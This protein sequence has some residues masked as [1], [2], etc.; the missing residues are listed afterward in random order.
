MKAAPAQS[1]Q[2]TLARSG[3]S[4]GRDPTE[5]RPSLA[6]GVLPM[7]GKTLALEHTREHATR[8][9]PVGTQLRAVGPP[10]LSRALRSGP[11]V[12]AQPRRRVGPGPGYPR[13]RPPPLRAISPGHQRARVALHDHV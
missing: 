10:P 9:H 6:E 8:E 4:M 13:A 5:S 2:H 3:I 11:P 12:R 1:V 7:L